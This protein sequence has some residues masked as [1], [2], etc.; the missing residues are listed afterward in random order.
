M[1]GS[2]RVLPGT[3]ELGC[4]AFVVAAVLLPPSA[5]AMGDGRGGHG[6]EDRDHF[7]N[8]I[9]N[10]SN[11]RL[12]SAGEDPSKSAGLPAPDDKPTVSKGDVEKVE[13]PATAAP[14]Q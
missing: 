1:A 11:R 9:L 8:T 6:N 10:W 4:A 3:L 7:G 12:P 13:A 2:W 5:F 14:P